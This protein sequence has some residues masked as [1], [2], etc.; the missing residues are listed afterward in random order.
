[1][2]V[3]GRLAQSRLP[4]GVD[5]EDYGIRGMDLAYALGDYDVAVLVD[6][7]PRGAAA[8]TVYLI[9]PDLDDNAA[10][11]DTHGMDPVKVLALARHLGASLPRVLVV[12]CEPASIPGEDAEL[13]ADLS[14]P[15]RAAIGEAV[16]MV[17]SLLDDLCA[18]EAG[19]NDHDER[20]RS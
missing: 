3:A 18:D 15:V 8:G 7:L 4:A 20:E 16:R 9:E 12:G 17:E 1:V 19:A 10:A 14:E 13:S 5:V 2:A 11:I 6:A